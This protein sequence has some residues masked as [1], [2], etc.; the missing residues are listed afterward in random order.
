MCVKVTSYLFTFPKLNTKWRT[1][2]ASRYLTWRSH[3][4]VPENGKVSR[5]DLPYSAEL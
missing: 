2:E 3:A 4:D 5:V 1:T